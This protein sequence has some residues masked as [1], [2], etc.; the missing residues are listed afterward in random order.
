MDLALDSLQWLICHKTEP[1]PNQ[2]TNQPVS[3]NGVYHVHINLN[4][5]MYQNTW[6]ELNEN[7]CVRIL[8]GLDFQKQHTAV[9]FFHS[10]I[11]PKLKVN[12]L[13]TKIYSLTESNLLVLQLFASLKLHV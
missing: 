7:L 13:K 1:T 9:T 11:V 8:L 6:P 3:I 12:E 4:N 2:P 10:G 5:R